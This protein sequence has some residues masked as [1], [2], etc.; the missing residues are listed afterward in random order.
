MECL[1]K[2]NKELVM[3]TSKSKSDYAVLKTQFNSV[4]KKKDEEIYRL[5]LEQKAK[6]QEEETRY[7]A[8]ENKYNVIKKYE[9]EKIQQ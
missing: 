2:E 1:T 9:K 4:E 7:L 6:D 3:K 8:L 5:K